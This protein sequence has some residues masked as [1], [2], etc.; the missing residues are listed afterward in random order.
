MRSGI[1]RG[2]G[3]LITTGKCVEQNVIPAFGPFRAH[4]CYF[5]IRFKQVKNGIWKPFLVS[6]C[7]FTDMSTDVKHNDIM[8]FE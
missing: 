5:G 4:S 6:L 8:S 3:V 2:C 7:G 1:E